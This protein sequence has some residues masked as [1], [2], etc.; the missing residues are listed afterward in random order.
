[1]FYFCEFEFTRNTQLTG[2]NSTTTTTTTTTIII[3]DLR[4][5]SRAAKDYR[6]RQDVKRNYG[7]GL[8]QMFNATADNAGCR[9]PRSDTNLPYPIDPVLRSTL[10]LLLLLRRASWIRFSFTKE[11]NTDFPLF[12]HEIW[13]IRHFLS[14]NLYWLLIRWQVIVARLQILCFLFTLMTS[15][16]SYYRSFIFYLRRH[17]YFQ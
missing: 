3:G 9:Y 5:N 13:Y 17:W 10:L 8:A 1:M 2:K 14:T 12:F 16:L 4:L 11:I 7:R 15:S 6:L